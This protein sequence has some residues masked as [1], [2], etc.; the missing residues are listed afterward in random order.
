[1][2]VLDVS[3]PS[4]CP[5]LQPVADFLQHRFSSVQFSKP[6]VTYVGNINARAL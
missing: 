2:T 6:Q 4:H 1:M 5:L 3:V